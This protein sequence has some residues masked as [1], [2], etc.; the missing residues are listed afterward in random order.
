MNLLKVE[1]IFQIKAQ[2]FYYK[3]SQ[4]NITTLF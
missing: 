3:C 2:K 4:K 1:D